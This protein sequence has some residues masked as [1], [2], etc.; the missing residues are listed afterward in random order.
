MPILHKSSADTFYQDAS[1]FTQTKSLDSITLRVLHWGGLR[2]GKPVDVASNDAKTNNESERYR[3]MA[4]G[5]VK[6][7]NNA[8]GFGFILA[9]GTGEDLFAHYSSIQMNGYKTLKA[10]Q[11]V[12]YDLIHGPK[13]LHAAN[14][15]PVSTPENEGKAPEPLTN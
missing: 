2:E 4:I 13:G 15:T 10:G 14:I 1:L 9:E 11:Q 8:K 12:S 7:F 6:W 5:T 3:N